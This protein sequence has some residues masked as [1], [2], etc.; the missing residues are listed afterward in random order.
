MP[1]DPILVAETR[2][3]I[4]KAAAD[5]RAAKHDLVATPPILADATFHCQQAVEKLFKGFLMWHGVP[6]RKTHSL[7]EL[8]EQCLDLD[9]ALRDQVDRAVPLTEYAWK[10]RY[11]GEPEEPSLEEAE[12]AL[13]IAQ[14]VYEAILARLPEEVM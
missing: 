9:A 10:F 6:F 1:L 2:S 5:L 12:E 8:G 7:E 4:S 3:W 14:E 11:P 13:Q